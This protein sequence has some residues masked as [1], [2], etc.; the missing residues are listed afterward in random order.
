[1]HVL[2]NETAKNTG[3]PSAASEFVQSPFFNA[4]KAISCQG[5]YRDF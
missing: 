5:R 1:M 3:V 2:E 4:D